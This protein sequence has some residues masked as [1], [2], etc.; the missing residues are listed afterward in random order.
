MCS[1]PAFTADQTGSALTF[2]GTQ[3]QVNMTLVNPYSGASFSISGP[4]NYNVSSYLGDGL[5]DVLTG[6]NLGDFLLVQDPIGTQ[7]ICGVETILAQN[8]F[9][10]MCLADD[11]V[12]LGDMLIVGGNH[13]DLIWANAGNDTLILNNG[14]DF[15]DGGPG[16]DI[17]EGGNGNDIVTLWPGSGFDSI[18]GG[19]GIVDNAILDRVDIRAIQSQILISPA[20]D[21]SYE[22]DIFYLGTPMAQIRGVEF[23]DMTDASIDLTTCTGGIGDVCNLC[24]NDALNGVEGCDD[25]NNVSGDGCAAD[26]TAE[27]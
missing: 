5:S 19:D 17:I 13:P 7:R 11:F 14:A 21:L 18:S 24:G 16:N 22:F 8:Q 4:F 15:A 2:L 3:Q 25:G 6:T 12:I 23:L 10:V 9:D 1:G 20:A 27:Y 26:C